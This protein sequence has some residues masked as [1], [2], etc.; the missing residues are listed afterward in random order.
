M[1]AAF[2]RTFFRCHT[3]TPP[4]I[5]KPEMSL[6]PHTQFYCFPSDFLQNILSLFKKCFFIFLVGFVLG[7]VVSPEEGSS[8]LPKLV[9]LCLS[10]L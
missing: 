10:F 8:L 2:T 4:E 5:H 6:R 7:L 9:V 3:N 1:P